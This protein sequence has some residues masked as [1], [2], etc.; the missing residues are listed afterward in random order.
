MVT[1]DDGTLKFCKEIALSFD[2]SS[3]YA[4]VYRKD[5]TDSFSRYDLHSNPSWTDL[6]SPPE[7]VTRRICYS[8]A[9][10]SNHVFVVG[11]V[12]HDKWEREVECFAYDI[13]LKQWR[14]IAP[15]PHVSHDTFTSYRLDLL[16]HNGLLFALTTTALFVYDI[17]KSPVGTWYM[18]N[19]FIRNKNHNRMYAKYQGIGVL[20]HNSDLL[21]YRKAGHSIVPFQSI[22]DIIAKK[23]Q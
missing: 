19:I 4:I 5:G 13:A 7:S 14:T 8:L 21:L 17:T 12:R 6:P 20:S 15:F 22:V 10:S 9:C 18:L 23:P 11:G 2:H 1:I 16:A 3:L